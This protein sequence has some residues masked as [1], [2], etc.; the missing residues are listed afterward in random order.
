MEGLGMSSTLCPPRLITSPLQP[1]P[2]PPQWRSD[3]SS[4]EALEAAQRAVAAEGAEEEGSAGGAP[5][6][7]ALDT[8]IPDGEAWRIRG[9]RRRLGALPSGGSGGATAGPR[10]WRAWLGP[11]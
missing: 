11:R 1:L 9:A 5:R 4:K 8:K 2:S 7:A 3:N 10:G 6:L